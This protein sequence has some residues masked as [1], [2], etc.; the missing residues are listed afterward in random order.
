[1]KNTIKKIRHVL[2]G[3]L[4]IPFVLTLTT[5]TTSCMRDEGNYVYTEVF[6]IVIDTL[7][8][9]GHDTIHISTFTNTAFNLAP[10]DTLR[11]KPIIRFDGDHSQLEFRW[12]V[13]TQIPAY[14]QVQ[15]GADMRWPAADTIWRGQELNW[16]A[17]LPVAWYRANL[18]VH[19][20]ITGLRTFRTFDIR[21]QSPGSVGTR[22]VMLTYAN[23]QTDIELY[24]SSLGQTMTG[25]PSTQP[26]DG[27]YEDWGIWV[28]HNH[29][30]RIHGEKIPG[31]PIFVGRA[32]PAEPAGTGNVYYV[33]TDQTALALNHDGLPIM[34]DWGGMFFQTPNVKNPQSLLWMGNR[35]FIV[36]DG[37]LHVLYTNQPNDRRFSAPIGG[38]Y[39]AHPFLMRNSGVSWGQTLGAH[40]IIFDKLSYSFRPWFPRSPTIG[41]FS[42]TSPDAVVD[43][44]NLGG[45]PRAILEIDGGWVICVMHINGNDSLFVFNFSHADVGNF[46][47]PMGLRS[48]RAI[49]CPEIANAQFF[50]SS[51]SGGSRAFFYATTERVFSYGLESGQATPLLIHEVEPGQEITYIFQGRGGGFPRAGRMIF[52]AVW[53]NNTNQ[54]KIIEYAVVT[55]DG[56]INYPI[57]TTLRHPN[58]AITGGFGRIVSI[59]VPQD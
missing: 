9:V 20:P 7:G 12:F 5:T 36:N 55:L 54:G 58:P 38:D 59:T 10:G 28:S 2:W 26:P 34:M 8:L 6:P 27:D 22:L 16:I 11:F 3:L 51:I 23:G 46:S 56:T 50:T 43:A 48:R 17:D 49:N 35:Q 30:S 57:I 42:P 47:A 18:M 32:N 33:F 41:Q 13:R 19:D 4:L 1:M 45:I 24:A 40:Q 15:V 53:C 44:N 39:Y 29:F 52:I 25:T 21:I 31:K 14:T 37:Q